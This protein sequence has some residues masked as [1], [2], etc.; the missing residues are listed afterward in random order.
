MTATAD[1]FAPQHRWDRTFFAAFLAIAWIGVLFGFWPA[2]SARFAGKADYAAP[3]I[4][5]I[6]ALAFVGWMLLL[7]TQI[8]LVR[9]GRVAVHRRL[10]MVGAILIPVMAVTA[11][12]SELYSQRFYLQRDEGGLDFFILPL[13]YIAAFAT[14]ATAALIAARKDRSAHKRLLLLATAVIVGAAYARWWGPYLTE[15]FGDDFWGMLINTFTG[16]NLILLSALAYDLA[17]RKRPHRV[18]L[19]A[20]P[21]LLAAEL[22]CSFIYHAAWWPPLSRRIIEGGFLAAG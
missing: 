20:V 8:L 10:G 1:T 7:T 17:T 18:Y 11:V 12:A 2:S 22:A 21:A 15:A 6:H 16:T 14:L 4:L 3:L 19:V 9:A 13:F 5:Q